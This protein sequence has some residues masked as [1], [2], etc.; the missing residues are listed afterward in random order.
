MNPDGKPAPLSVSVPAE[1]PAEP[2][3][4][5]VYSADEALP[6]PDGEHGAFISRGEVF[7]TCTE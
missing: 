2:V 3:N 1:T 4:V 6:S 7:V 5:S